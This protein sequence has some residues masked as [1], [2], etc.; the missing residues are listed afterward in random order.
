MVFLNRTWFSI[1]LLKNEFLN[2]IF[3]IIFTR[4]TEYPNFGS[5]LN[6]CHYFFII[7]DTLFVNKTLR[8]RGVS[9]TFTV[10]KMKLFET[11]AN[12]FQSIFNFI[13]NSILDFLGVLDTF[14]K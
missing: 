3:P 13:K 9:R 11:L 14:R 2:K 7:N 4:G 1:T 8:G 12:N 10:S 6:D 5:H